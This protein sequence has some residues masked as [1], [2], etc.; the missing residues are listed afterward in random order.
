[1]MTI[2]YVSNGKWHI[3]QKRDLMKVSNIVNSFVYDEIS[4]LFGS[5]PNYISIDY[6]RDLNMVRV[7][8]CV[9]VFKWFIKVGRGRKVNLGSSREFAQRFKLMLD[10]IVSLGIVNAPFTNVNVSISTNIKDSINPRSYLESSWALK[11]NGYYLKIR[12]F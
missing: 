6:D 11:D 4:P 7:H 2:N 12:I 3:R 1:M 5:K 9:K 8:K 10:T